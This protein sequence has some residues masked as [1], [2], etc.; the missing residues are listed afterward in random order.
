[1][2][3]YNTNIIKV[4]D[5]PQPFINPSNPI[6]TMDKAR[7]NSQ[8]ILKKENDAKQDKYEEQS[9][10]SEDN[11]LKN[12]D[13]NILKNKFNKQKLSASTA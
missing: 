8:R 3:L 2:V 4:M 7:T 12:D 11:I 1:M 10:D 13:D 6:A 9:N 5:Y